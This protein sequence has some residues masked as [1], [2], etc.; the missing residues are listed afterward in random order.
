MRLLLLFGPPAVGKM[1]VGYEVSKLTGFK[2]LHNHMTIEPVLEI[3]DYGSPPFTRLVTEFRRRIVE[4]AVAADLPGLI[5]SAVWALDDPGDKA[6]VDAFVAIVTAAGGS[7]HFA[8]LYAD[9]S[10]R[11]TRNSTALRLDRKRSKR[12]LD[13][14]RHNLL[15]TDAQHIMNTDGTFFYPDAHIR[16][17]NSNLSAREAA[18]RIIERFGFPRLVG[19]HVPTGA[20][21]TS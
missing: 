3:F 2:L 17:D 16:I 11:L 13:F 1:T 20:G 19:Q 18:E 4:E 14:S 8:E 5:F 9:Q 10:V 21:S 12:D 7:A 15:E 6:L